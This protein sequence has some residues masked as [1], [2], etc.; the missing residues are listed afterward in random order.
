MDRCTLLSKPNQ[1]QI[2]RSLIANFAKEQLLGTLHLSP[3]KS[4]TT[5]HSKFVSDERLWPLTHGEL[6]SQFWHLYLCS[7]KNKRKLNTEM[8][9]FHA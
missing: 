7:E 2:S 3:G 9:S 5:L 8:I 6:F 4:R 1:L